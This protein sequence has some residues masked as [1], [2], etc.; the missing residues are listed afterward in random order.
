[1]RYTSRTF[2]EDKR[3]CF[4]LI[5]WLLSLE[6]VGTAHLEAICCQM[7]IGQ[8]E[9]MFYRLVLCSLQLYW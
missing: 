4:L 2:Y 5:V 9:A 7:G 6:L 3:Y 1:M 8:Q